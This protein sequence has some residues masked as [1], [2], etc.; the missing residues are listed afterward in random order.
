MSTTNNDRRSQSR[1]HGYAGELKVIGGSSNPGLAAAIARHLGVPL[2]EVALGRFR[3]GEVRFQIKDNVRGADVF[4]V[5]STSPPVNENLM[6]LLIM[7]DA[8]KRASAAR[9]NA[10]V[11]YYGYARQDRKDRPR[12][13]ISAKLVA[14]LLTVAGIHRVICM[15]LHVGQIQGFFDIP[16]DHL[17]ATP[18]VLDHLLG[19]E[20]ERP[21]V[22]SPDAGGVERARAYGKK[23]GVGI[24]VMDKRRGSDNEVETMHVVGDVRGRSAVIVDDIVDSAG[25]LVRAAE[26]LHADGATRVLAVCTH[27]VLSGPAVARIRNGPL[28]RLIVGDTIP[29]APDARAAD[30]RIEVLSVASLFARAIESVHGEASVS[31]LFV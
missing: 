18:V 1:T 7:V 20:L 27:A 9:I 4:V 30:S 26:A 13:P 17:Y 28:E 3:D 14:D 25:T 21:I 15:D 6:E 16:V 12:V 19:L 8:L 5:Q 22:V 23:L 24:A 29:L 31:S 2:C 11:P 10:V